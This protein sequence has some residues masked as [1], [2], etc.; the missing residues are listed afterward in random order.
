MGHGH[1]EPSL[2]CETADAATFFSHHGI[3]VQTYRRD[4]VDGKNAFQ[5]CQEDLSKTFLADMLYI[6]PMQTEVPRLLDSPRRFYSLGTAGE[7]SAV[8]TRSAALA[9]PAGEPANRTGIESKDDARTS[10]E[11]RARLRRLFEMRQP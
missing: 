10:F 2:T 8:P 11:L 7:I 3:F 6:A 1:A 5:S 4:L 9:V